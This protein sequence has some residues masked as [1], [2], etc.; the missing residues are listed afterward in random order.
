MS[1]IIPLSQSIAH[2]I[3]AKTQKHCKAEIA[4]RSIASQLIVGMHFRLPPHGREARP[5]WYRVHH[6]E[7]TTGEVT[8]KAI[9]STARGIQ[10]SP[11]VKILR[12]VSEDKHLA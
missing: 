5:G 12:L 1:A 2:R 8:A 3:P 4:M 10:I 11:N 7:A 6:I 9:A